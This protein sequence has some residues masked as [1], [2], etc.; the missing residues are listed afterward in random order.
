[1]TAASL[2]S[3]LTAFKNVTSPS[4]DKEK[5]AVTLSKRLRILK[6]RN[7]AWWIIMLLLATGAIGAAK[8]Y[9]SSRNI[10]VL[11]SLFNQS[12]KTA[13]AIKKTTVWN[14]LARLVHTKELRNILERE[15]F[16]SLRELQNMARKN[17]IQLTQKQ[18]DSILGRHVGNVGG[19]YFREGRNLF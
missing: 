17:G 15:P 14:S 8:Y 13:S 18:I 10:N 5:A 4:L 3:T 6:K 16:N 12:R 2:K 19:I 11:P 1:M 7:H 9:A